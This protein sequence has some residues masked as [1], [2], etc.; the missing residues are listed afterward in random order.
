MTEDWQDAEEVS[1]LTHPTPV[2]QD[3]PFIK[4]HSRMPAR[5]PQPARRGA[6]PV[7]IPNRAEPC[8][9]SRLCPDGLNRLIHHPTASHK[10]ERRGM[11]KKRLTDWVFLGSAAEE[12]VDPIHSILSVDVGE[13]RH[14]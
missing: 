12:T 11:A 4:Q 6:S 13:E 5:F 3:A 9:S 8:F 7:P 1:I 10:I 2:R 14:R